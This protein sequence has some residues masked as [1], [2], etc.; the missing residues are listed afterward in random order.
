MNACGR[1]FC[2]DYLLFLCSSVIKRIGGLVEKGEGF[3][4][5]SR[6]G[7][8]E[9]LGLRLVKRR[10]LGGAVASQSVSRGEVTD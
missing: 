4:S 1:G 2:E 10:G 5:E 8:R 3:D 6:K 9:G 7:F